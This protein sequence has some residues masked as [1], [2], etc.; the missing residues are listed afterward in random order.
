MDSAADPIPAA[1][2]VLMRPGPRAPELLMI[3]R[4]AAMAFAP[5]ALVFPGGRVDPD[6]RL[7]GGDDEARFGQA[8][9][10]LTGLYVRALAP[11]SA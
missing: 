7:L 6:D 3:E 5:G 4:T 11:G 10:F 1:T 2:L 9:D 8:A